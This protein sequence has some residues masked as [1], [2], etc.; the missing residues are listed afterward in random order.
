[1]ILKVKGMMC[2]HCER[3]VR[4]CLEDLNFINEAVPDFK[5]GTVRVVTSGQPDMGQ[6]KSEIRKAGYKL[7]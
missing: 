1:M 7:L 6:I 2:E 3:R 4:E 5:S